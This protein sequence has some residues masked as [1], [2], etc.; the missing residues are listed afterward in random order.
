M[1]EIKEVGRRDWGEGEKRYK[2]WKLLSH[3]V[4]MCVKV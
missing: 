3:K 1:M 4:L 2:M